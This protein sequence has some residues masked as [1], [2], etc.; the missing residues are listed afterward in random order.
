MYPLNDLDSQ[1]SLMFQWNLADSRKNLKLHW[2]MMVLQCNLV[3]QANLIEAHRIRLRTNVVM[4]NW[5]EPMR[6]L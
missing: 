1:S 6:R 2:S 3:T 5:S 4:V